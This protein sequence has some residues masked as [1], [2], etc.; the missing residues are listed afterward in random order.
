[1]LP[2]GARLVYAEDA[3]GSIGRIPKDP[4]NWAEQDAA[5]IV[6]AGRKK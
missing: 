5:T 4:P 2:K 6:W 3:N 1:M